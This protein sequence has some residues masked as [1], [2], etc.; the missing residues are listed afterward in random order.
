M[1]PVVV[2]SDEIN[3]VDFVA[4]TVDWLPH[5]TG[6]AA[7]SGFHS[8]FRPGQAF[9]YTVWPDDTRLNNKAFR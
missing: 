2:V 5:L 7:R 9:M 3:W 8:V 4:E 1:R 6:R